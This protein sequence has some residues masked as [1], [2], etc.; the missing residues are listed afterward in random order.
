MEPKFS[1]RQNLLSTSDLER[2]CGR[3]SRDV[4]DLANLSGWPGLPGDRI[5]V[6]VGT[7]LNMLIL[8]NARNEG[9][10][11]CAMR[12]WLPGLRNE[13]LLKTGEDASNWELD[14]QSGKEQQFW[15][16]FWGTS[17]AIRPRVAPLLG[18]CQVTTIRRLRFHSQTDV[19]CLS[20]Q[21]VEANINDGR[22]PRFM[23]DA[24]D[25]AARVRAICSSRLFV[26]K[27][28]HWH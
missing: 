26:A 24:H 27:V 10:E 21:Q 3:P 22:A 2:L 9:V 25:L 20:N 4:I 13:A 17:D 19:E 5:S 11:A 28:V 18:C 23:I 16:L 14:D 12:P 1:A 15:K 8:S 6:P 7:A